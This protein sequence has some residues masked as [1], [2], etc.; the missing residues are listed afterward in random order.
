MLTTSRLFIRPVQIE[1]AKNLY[2]LNLDPE[3]VRYTGDEAFPSVLESQKLIQKR[4]IPQFQKPGMS[5]FIVFQGTEFIGWCGL[6]YH[7]E[8]DEVDLGYRLARKFWG[9]GFATEASLA[10]LDYGFN[11]LNIN[12]IIAKAMPQNIA[13]LKILIKLGMKH[14]GFFHDPTD[15]HPFVLYELEKKDFRI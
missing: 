12:R 11:K 3:V 2:E 4:M 1:D 15:P 13:S 6:K 8:T 9:N 14:K 7:P 10:C 5:R